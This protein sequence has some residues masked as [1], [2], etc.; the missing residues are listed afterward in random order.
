[1]SRFAHPLIRYHGGKFRLSDWIISFF[2]NHNVYVEPFGGGASVLLN[3][4]PSRVE[5]YNDL[6]DDVVNFFKVLRNKELAKQLAEA[7]YLTP[8]SRTE[9][10]NARA[11]SNDMVE[12]A[13]RLV[14]RAQMGF[15]SAGATK[16]NTGFRL[17]TARGGSDIVTIWQRQPKV[18]L[19]AAERLKKVLIENRDALKVIEDHDRED[20][21]FF[22]DPPYVHETRSMGGSAY[23]CE[24]T[25]T[26]HAELVEL[27]KLVKGKVILC[28]YE[29]YI[30]DSLNWKKV[31][32][33]V[34]AAGQSGSVHREEVLWINPQAEK[35]V[36]LFSEVTV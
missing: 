12:K 21:L 31:K 29:H 13:R 26:Q 36:D 11:D 9:F 8:Y 28:G 34:A 15:G 23:R 17:D 35:Q 33:T 7:I 18:V 4:E 22:I 1:M 20:T 2:P 16:G 10:L 24:M 3:K 32:K 19:Q 27:L 30:Y 6:D 25:N 5:V 14:I